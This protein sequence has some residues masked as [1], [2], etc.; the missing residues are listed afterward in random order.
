MPNKAS[1]MLQVRPK[2]MPFSVAM[3]CSTEPASSSHPFSGESACRSSK[4]SCPHCSPCFQ[5]P[6]SFVMLGLFL[7]ALLTCAI[8]RLLYYGLSI[9]KG[10]QRTNSAIGAFARSLREAPL[11]GTRRA[12]PYSALASLLSF[13]A[14]IRLHA[15]IIFCFWLVNI[16]CI[17]TFYETWAGPDNPRCVSLNATF[18]EYCANVS[19]ACRFP[20]TST[21][22]QRIKYF[23]D[24]TAVL[25][26]S[27]LPIVI[28]LSGRNSLA[29]L[30]SGMPFSMQML[31]HRWVGRMVALLALCHG[32]GYTATYTAFG[33]VTYLYLQPYVPFGITV[34]RS[35]IESENGSATYLS[36]FLQALVAL[37]CSCFFSLPTIRKFSYEVFL[38]GHIMFAAL[39][40]GCAFTHV[41]KQQDDSRVG[42]MLLQR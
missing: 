31:Y 3:I 32:A 11:F 6:L 25:C 22:T 16:L 36:F 39:T 7:T 30:L 15:I 13:R 5:Q 34:R 9:F 41:K 26:V 28:L 19:S 2:R 4:T 38:L 37:C 21:Y 35:P 29:A 1:P 40:L 42:S 23:S 27:Y 20:M 17:A 12:Q 14:P 33:G 24:R 18:C 8:I 10:R